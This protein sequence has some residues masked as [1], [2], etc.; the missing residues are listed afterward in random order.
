MTRAPEVSVKCELSHADSYGVPILYLIASIYK[1][2][3]CSLVV[4]SIVFFSDG[5]YSATFLKGIL[6]KGST[7]RCCT[8]YACRQLG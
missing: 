2:D 7:F 3:A 1:V 4:E 6:V 5:N 8:W